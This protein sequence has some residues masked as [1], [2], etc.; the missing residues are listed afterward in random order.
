MRELMTVVLLILGFHV[1]AQVNH[2][3]TVV[4]ETDEWHYL[5]PSSP[6]DA[7]WVNLNFDD[8]AWLTGNGGIGYGDDDDQTTITPTL[9][10]FMRLRF[11]ITDLDVVKQALLQFDYDDGIVIYLNGQE[12]ARRNVA[13]SGIP[14][15]NQTAIDDREALLYQGGEP[16][17]VLIGGQRLTT[18]LNEGDNVLAVQVHNKDETSSDL[19]A[20]VWLHAGISNNRRDYRPT[21]GI[22][23]PPAFSSTNLPL[24]V[25][26][27][28]EEIPDEPKVLGNMQIIHNGSDQRNYLG[29]S[30]NEYNGFIGIEIRGSS[31]AIF[32][33][34]SYGLETR[35]AQGE[36]NNVSLFGM[37]SENDWILNGPFSDKSLLRNVLT[38][39]MGRR[40]GHWVPRTQL[41]EVFIN[42]DY[43][44]VY[45]F[46]EKI[47]RDNGRVDIAKLTEEDNA[48]DELTG[49][50]IV[51]LDKETGGDAIAWTSPFAPL[52]G[53]F[54]S[55]NYLL[56]YP[57]LPDIT[58][59]Q[60]EYIS[61]YITDFE[62]AIYS[63][64]LDDP[65]TGYKNYID[66]N[67][68]VDYIL[69]TELCKN[70]DSYRISTFLYKK[71]D[72]NGGK[73][74]AG[75]LWDYNLA[76][77][78]VDYCE[79]NLT[80]GWEL[81][82]NTVCSGD[83]WLNPPFWARM[84]TADTAFANA[85]NCR[86]RELRSGPWHTDSI[87]GFIDEQVSFLEEAQP[88]NFSR[89]PILG[90]YVWPNNFVGST[91]SEEIDY[92]KTWTL[93][94]LDFMDRFMFG[95]CSTGTLDDDEIYIQA[96]PNPASEIL[97]FDIFG[98]GEGQQLY[99]F[100][101]LGQLIH[102]QTIL[103]PRITLE[104]QTLPAGM[105]FYVVGDTDN[106]IAEGKII[107]H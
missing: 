69:T 68:F 61:S 55:T 21:T 104:V 103:T 77:G 51:K 18:I 47:K 27:T 48:G 93:Q 29:D 84:I 23:S 81:D 25:I 6:V 66:V 20:R 36:N 31:S 4:F 101:S 41:C 87:M 71:K 86:W 106:R 82:F 57:E 80:S 94:R 79:A 65:A 63:E 11:E 92:L 52:S 3:E 67:S 42:G 75:P 96:F 74:Y 70:I 32:P 50:Y 76:W 89:W 1:C 34:K 85:M 46:M 105:Y 99:L 90:E 73:L 60:L 28:N 15:F 40:T 10:C 59:Q 16:E 88:R 39:E 107:I 102:Q 24:V 53:G 95:S 100:N 62:S 9:S 2:W 33:K 64:N 43:R 5:L 26:N 44:G 37:P 54:Q 45:V 8:T 19:S 13:G 35:D 78:N 98:V 30:G 7:D 56:H 12:V 49:G 17:H 91:Y 22:F 58:D 38:F 72:S 97:N 14:A 83:A